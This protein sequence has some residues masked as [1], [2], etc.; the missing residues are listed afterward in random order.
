MTSAA[1]ERLLDAPNERA[2]WELFADEL[3]ARG[4]LRGE[5]ISLAL[6]DKQSRLALRLKKA[7]H[8]F[9][10]ELE[11][12]FEVRAKV[13]FEKGLWHALEAAE[14]ENHTASLSLGKL[15]TELLANPMA[16]LPDF[17]ALKHLDAWDV[18]PLTL[19]HAAIR[20]RTAGR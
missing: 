10:G 14:V 2:A 9:L 16:V 12:D 5:L 3:Q 6:N 11:R 8:R 15:V 17:P 7:H 1:I 4:D 20:E 18:E 19:V 13:T